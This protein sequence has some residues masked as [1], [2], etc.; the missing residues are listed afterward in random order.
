MQSIWRWIRINPI[1]EERKRLWNIYYDINIKEETRYIK[2][3][4]EILSEKK[5]LEI[6]DKWTILET[7]FLFS[8]KRD[9]L[10]KVVEELDNDDVSK[11]DFLILDLFDKSNIK[12]DLYYPTYKSKKE[13]K[14]KKYKIRFNKLK[15]LKKYIQTKWNLLLLLD[16]G[17]NIKNITLLDKVLSNEENY[18]KITDSVE[19]NKNIKYLILEIVNFLNYK[20]EEVDDFKLIDWKIDIVSFKN[21]A[22]SITDKRKLEEL[23]E[24]INSKLNEEYISEEKLDEMFDNKEISREEYKEKLKNIWQQVDKEFTYENKTINIKNIAKHYYNP[25]L[26]SN[27]EKIEWIKHIVDV[28]SEVAF[29]NN[30]EENQNIL[31]EKFDEWYFSKLDHYLDITIRI[32]YLDK[33]SDKANFIPDFIFWCKKGDNYEIFFIDP[34]WLSFTNYQRKIDYFK[35]LFEE[36]GNQKIFKQWKMNIKVNLFIYNINDTPPEWYEK[37]GSTSIYNMFN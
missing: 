28:E 6:R 25:V 15:E 19:N 29:L 7:L 3:L 21:I 27:N 37:Y 17:L 11:S 1:F 26:I 16:N 9:E 8:T 33:N 34:K 18:F 32:P 35:D 30:L 24:K 10:K 5:Y 4:K 36:N 23:K 14:Q 31:N 12:M 2:E 22:V 20:D 13:E